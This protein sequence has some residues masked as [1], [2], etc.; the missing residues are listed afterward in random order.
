MFFR[1]RANP[2][3]TNPSNTNPDIPNP[4]ATNP[5]TTNPSATNS[6]D[7][8]G[9][10]SSTITDPK[11]TMDPKPSVDPKPA[12]D[13][14]GT[15]SRQP[16][17]RDSSSS[18]KAPDTEGTT[19]RSS[20][21]GTQRESQGATPRSTA[22]QTVTTPR[23][24]AGQTTTTP[25]V[26]SML[27]SLWEQPV[28]SSD[29]TSLRS[30][31]SPPSP[32]ASPSAS[33]STSATPRAS[34]SD[35]LLP[36][37]A[38]AAASAPA[39]GRGRGSELGEVAEVVEGGEAELS[40]LPAEGEGARPIVP[41]AAPVDAAEPAAVTA[42]VPA[43]LTAAAAAGSGGD[44]SAAVPASTAVP[45]A[46][47][48]A[49]AAAAAAAGT[50][51]GGSDYED[52][53]AAA[54]GGMQPMTVAPEA[55]TPPHL[56]LPLG[57]PPWSL[58]HRLYTSACHAL[59][60]TLLPLLLSLSLPL[61]HSPSSP[62]EEAKPQ[63][64]TT[65]RCRAGQE[66]TVKASGAGAGGEVPL[67]SGSGSEPWAL[68]SAWVEGWQFGC[69]WP[70]SSP[71]G[72]AW[73]VG[74]AALALLLLPVVLVLGIPVLLCWI[75]AAAFLSALA[76]LTLPPLRITA[77]RVE[78]PDGRHVAVCEWGAAASDARE[79][80][81]VL[82]GTPSC[83]LVGI[84]MVDPSLL[85]ARR[86]RVVS[87]DRPGIGQ[88]D[89]LPGWDLHSSAADLLHL[90]PLLSLPPKFWVLG[91]SGGGPHALA[92]ARFLPER[93][94]GVLLWAGDVNPWDLVDTM[95]GEK[96]QGET[97]RGRKGSME[98]GEAET[99]ESSKGRESRESST[100]SNSFLSTIHKRWAAWKH[101]AL[102]SLSLWTGL[103]FAARLRFECLRWIP[104]RVVPLLFPLL[105]PPPSFAFSRLC[106][107]RLLPSSTRCS[108]MC[109]GPMH[110][111]SPTLTPFTCSQVWI[112]LSS[113][114]CQHALYQGNLQAVVE[115]LL[116][117]AVPW[118]FSL[119]DLKHC[120]FPIHI[121]QGT[122]DQDV[123]VLLSDL[124]AHL[125]PCVSLHLLHGHG[126]YSPFTHP[127]FHR[128]FLDTLTVQ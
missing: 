26:L 100:S 121:W 46:A 113:S 84:P 117:P 43:A 126:H 45:A 116:L 15:T 102:F 107:C 76:S 57:S 119:N 63:Q 75:A 122:D 8:A 48:A 7:T 19:G 82:H 86:I 10:K 110:R 99:E 17:G 39:G 59:H 103:P 41:R 101:A 13:P 106:F 64:G 30:A 27:E 125:L 67:P 36:P 97:Q 16:P 80:I 14:T 105:F 96:E 70:L 38:V 65:G 73:A 115:D 92:V 44:T 71:F 37:T 118:G 128:V 111:H 60:T 52:G 33:A 34:I 55:P 42:A 6:S 66:G 94:A 109:S 77:R 98:W 51:D 85:R 104:P 9:L 21:G 23:S 24:T 12:M 95:A 49:S 79:T 47:P 62:G 72:P 31:S 61:S 123:P 89:Y 58:A 88:S 93:L 124:L 114:T 91:Y 22:G 40:E 3:S 28:A 74:S 87:F 4:G 120:D 32:S 11:P 25:D 69:Y 5:S 50:D 83:R 29:T 35:T 81:L 78:L 90:A 1:A 53:S 2:N 68:A 54:P 18:T 108:P 127:D 20:R 56:P 112:L